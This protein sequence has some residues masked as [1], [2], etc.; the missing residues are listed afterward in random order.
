MSKKQQTEKSTPPKPKSALT[1]F[2]EGVDSKELPRKKDQ[3][4][5]WFPLPPKLSR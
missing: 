4:I 5:V 1:V 2:L 3:T